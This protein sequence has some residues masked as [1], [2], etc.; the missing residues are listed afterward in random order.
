MIL[1]YFWCLSTLLSGA[2]AMGCHREGAVSAALIEGAKDGVTLSIA[3]AGPIA[4]WSGL[5][6]LLE[7]IGLTHRL[8]QILAPLLHRLYPSSKSDPQLSHALSGN[9]C[10]NLL[11]LGN[12][13]TPMGI[14]AVTRLQSPTAP[15]TATDEM[16]R[17]VVMN[18]ASIQLIPSTV[19]AL[20]TAAGCQTPFDILPLV[21][22][23]SIC[24][25]SA[26]LLAAW[27]LGRIW[28]DV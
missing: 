14:Q 12:A 16:C 19:A 24:S 11:G 17:L 3:L 22:M 1:T 13:A 28:K 10:A 18:T 7:S 20:R 21:W 2:F 26:G 5:G 27:A 8:A 4:L 23:S 9:F 25:V 15:N 6:N